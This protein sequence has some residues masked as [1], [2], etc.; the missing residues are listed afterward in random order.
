M[1]KFFFGNYRS[2]KGYW[3]DS[4]VTKRIGTE[5]YINKGKRFHHKRHVNLIR[6]RYIESIEQNDMELPMGVLLYDAFEITPP[7]NPKALVDVPLAPST[8]YS[9]QI[10]GASSSLTVVKRKSLREKKAVKRL[11]SNPKKKY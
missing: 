9:R 1:I 2:G 11:C 6:P 8:S 3:E 5:I 7:I 4:I 10:P